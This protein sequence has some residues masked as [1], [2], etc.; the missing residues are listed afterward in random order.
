[1]SPGTEKK[2]DQQNK[3]EGSKRGRPLPISWDMSLVC[4]ECYS[5]KKF[6]S[7]EGCF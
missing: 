5:G 3:G 1:M 4:M 7:V 6:V 2:L